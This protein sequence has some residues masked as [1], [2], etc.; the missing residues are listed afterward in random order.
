MP[1]ER[2]LDDFIDAY[3]NYTED[4]EP[5]ELFRT[6]TAISTVAAA[7]QRRI[8][9]YWDQPL[10][11][12]MYIVLVAPGGKARKSTAMGY[13][14]D[15]LQTSGISISPEAV[16]RE[17][18]IKRLRMAK[19]PISED[20]NRIHSSLTA[21]SSELTVFI[22]FK[23]QTF[24]ADLC[25]WFDCP[26]GQWEYLTKTEKLKDTIEN[27]W[28]N[29]IAGTTPEV[30]V[31]ALPSEAI[32]SG[33]TSRMIFVFEEKKGKTVLIPPTVNRS[34]MSE[35]LDENKADLLNLREEL[36]QDITTILSISGEFL[37]SEE[38]LNAWSEFYGH[39]EANTKFQNTPLSSYWERRPIHTLKTSMIL[40]MA[41]SNDLV[42]EVQDLKRAMKILSA[43]E[44]KMP[45]T[46]GGVGKSEIASLVAGMAK[47]IKERKVTTLGEVVKAFYRDGDLDDIKKAMAVLRN[48][49]VIS[50]SGAGADMK[51]SIIEQK[52]GD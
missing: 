27:V 50:A 20:D 44:K 7:M 52:E 18:M 34:L 40:S 17:G 36:L 3:L 46:F 30:L 2:I 11:A 47:F 33:L 15:L 51:I 45:L 14:R 49:K 21:F 29:L 31:A 8:F 10:Y 12:N 23:N 38:F 37:P 9:F 13:G 39:H 42:L 35:D 32:G 25:D 1:E 24:M 5:P 26:Q 28:F 22:G 41:R 4:T 6:W 43:T 48:M 19:R 16:T